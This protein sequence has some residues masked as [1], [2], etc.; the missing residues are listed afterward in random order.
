MIKA[1]VTNIAWVVL[2]LVLLTGGAFFAF[3]KFSVSGGHLEKEECRNCHLASGPVTKENAGK[4]IASQERLCETCHKGVL[5]VS[6]PSG[7]SPSRNL[8][9]AFPL[10]WKG[11]LTCSS[12]HKVHE[13][14]EKMLRGGKRGKGLCL[15][16]HKPSF[17]KQMPDHGSSIIT[18][19]HV[20]EAPEDILL[21]VDS[22]SLD[23]MACHDDQA[24]SVPVFLD[25][26]GIVRHGS[27]AA[28][29]PVGVEY[30]KAAEYGGYRD[31]NSLDPKIFLPQG[32]VSCLSCHKG[33]SEKHGELVFAG[34]G[35]M[36]LC[37]ECHDL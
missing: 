18:K 16:C 2:P 4:L 17:F 15:S 37:M 32:K 35:G 10:D 29:H 8:P 26:S 33:Y 36:S 3:G 14:M 13:R 22:Y 20:R 34:R 19:G 6:H 5:A 31:I 28:N 21:P 7:F 11:D 27:G 1:P 12:C 23:C 9:G 30:R 25:R 24:N